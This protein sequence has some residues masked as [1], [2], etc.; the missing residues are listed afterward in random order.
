MFSFQ[1][2]HV[3]VTGATGGIGRAICEA[4]VRAKASKLAL[5]GRSEAAL[6]L[7]K[8]SLAALAP[9]D[10]TTATTTT[11]QLFIVVCRQADANG[12]A[13]AQQAL[14]QHAHAQMGGIDVL[15][16]NAGVTEDRASKN[17]SADTWQRVLDVNL[18]EPFFQAQAAFRL[19]HV[20]ATS[21]PPVAAALPSTVT[22]EAHRLSRVVFNTSIVG[23]TGNFGQANYCAS[24][25]ALTATAKTLARE[26]AKHGVT[27]NCVAPGFIDTRMTVGIP[28]STK[29]Q[30]VDQIPCKAFGQP[31]DVAAAMLYL[32]SAEAKYVTGHTLH[33]NGGLLMA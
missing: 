19:S 4:L 5:V 23:H 17:M 6:E 33:V 18:S 12:P 11:T 24:K 10:A 1:G 16:C 31:A 2:K 20:D 27:V 7:L 29:A 25:A 21:A 22:A 32:A 15:I 14:V 28:A 13:E 9:D 3:V 8:Q 26:Y 30:L